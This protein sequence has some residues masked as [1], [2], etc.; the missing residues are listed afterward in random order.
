[1]KILKNEVRVKKPKEPKRC[2]RIR[3]Y[4]ST[5][6]IFDQSIPIGQITNGSVMELIRVL[7]AKNLSPREL[8]G[9]YARRGTKIHNGFLEIHKEIQEEK[10]RMLYTCGNDPHYIACV[11]TF[12]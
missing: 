11:E 10:R 1:M 9:A 5:T 7:V 4:H 8:M 3:G 12:E 2:W 6:L